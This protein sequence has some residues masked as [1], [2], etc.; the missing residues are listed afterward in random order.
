MR[1][2]GPDDPVAEKTSQPL[3]V[4]RTAFKW[5]WGVVAVAVLALGWLGLY[6]MWN[7]VVFLFQL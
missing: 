3:P 5:P 1:K 2:D 7:G 6:L 4:G